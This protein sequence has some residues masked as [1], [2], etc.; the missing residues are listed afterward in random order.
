MSRYTSRRTLHTVTMNIA[1]IFEIT[2]MCTFTVYTYRHPLF[3]LTREIF[4]MR[5]APRIKLANIEGHIF[6]HIP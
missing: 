3:R 5:N 2:R 1:T 4:A 6:V